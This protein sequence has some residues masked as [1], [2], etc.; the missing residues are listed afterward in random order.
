MV[1]GC[2]IW[3]RLA[4][5]KRL[6]LVVWQCSA[7]DRGLQ[8]DASRYFASLP[9]RCRLSTSIGDYLGVALQHF[10]IT[11]VLLG[12]IMFTFTQQ[13]VYRLGSSRTCFHFCNTTRSR[14]NISN[15]KLRS[16]RR[17]TV[18]PKVH[19]LF[20]EFMSTEKAH[21]ESNLFFSDV[22]PDTKTM[23]ALRQEEVEG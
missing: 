13:P 15:K 1:S 12:G 10:F 16:A 14:S 2:L 11:V 9:R 4:L 19:N 5:A 20:L 17:C 22:R 21:C 18:A 23:V 7:Q 3:C 8:D 6:S